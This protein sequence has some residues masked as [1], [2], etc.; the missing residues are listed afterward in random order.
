M[1]RNT[2][3]QPQPTT[4]NRRNQ[5]SVQPG[6]KPLEPTAGSDEPLAPSIEGQSDEQPF[7]AF[8]ATGANITQQ[9]LDKVRLMGTV[10]QMLAEAH[11]IFAKAG[12]PDNSKAEP[13]GLVAEGQEKAAVAARR[14]YLACSAGVVSRDEISGL[15]VDIWG[16]KPRKDGQVGKTPNGQGEAIR[17]RIVRALA[18]RDF[19]TSG[20]G[21]AFFKGLDADAV[22]D[23]VND[24]D[25][26]SLSIY[27]AYNYLAELKKGTSTRVPLAFDAKRLAALAAKMAEPSSAEI[28]AKSQ[29]LLAAYSTLRRVLEVQGVEVGKQLKAMN[30]AQQEAE[31]AAMSDEAEADEAEAVEAEAEAV[32]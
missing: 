16:A 9:A 21:G 23:V 31:V 4:G 18:A 3:R 19:I 30:A 15:L 5:P 2:N 6:S 13:T 22:A 17:K 10:R 28:I 29:P 8:K 7:D 32:E 27:S 20:E 12:V 1:A 11:D 26:G 24:V 14:L 25:D